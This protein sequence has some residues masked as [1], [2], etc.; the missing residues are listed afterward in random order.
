MVWF[1]GLA[2]N[3]DCRT[4]ENL[5]SI[6][7]KIIG[8]LVLEDEG[9]DKCVCSIDAS[10]FLKVKSISSILPEQLSQMTVLA[11]VRYGTRGSI[12]KSMFMISRALIDRMATK[13]NLVARGVNIDLNICHFMKFVVNQS[14]IA[15][16]STL[17]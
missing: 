15:A 2:P 13:P 4:L 9:V 12:E 16:S 3:P 8:N 10:R 14:S 6:L 7:S 5:S 11:H 17:V 1:V